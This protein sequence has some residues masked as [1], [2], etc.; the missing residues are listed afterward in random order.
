ML[1]SLVGIAGAILPGL[2][3]PQ[4]G[5]IALIIIQFSLKYP[6]SRRFIVLW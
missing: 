1:L 5:Y 2:P 4:L 6:F 3:G